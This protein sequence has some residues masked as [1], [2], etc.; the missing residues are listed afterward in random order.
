MESVTGNSLCTTTTAATSTSTPTTVTATTSTISAAPT[1]AVNSSSNANTGNTTSVVMCSSNL[2][3]SVANLPANP[4]I[5]QV[6]DIKQDDSNNMSL[7][8]ATSDGQ[9]SLSGA[10]SASSSPILSPP[11]KIFGRNANGTTLVRLGAHDLTN[12][13]EAN[14]MD[15]RVKRTIVNENFDLKSIANDIA[16]IELST[17]APNTNFIGPI[18][19]PES[20]NFLTQDFVGMNP[21][22][23]GWGSIKYQGATSNVLRDAQ[24][25]IVNRQICEQSY[26]TVFNFINFSDRLICAGNS[27]VDRCQGEFWLALYD[28]TGTDLKYI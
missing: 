1:S 10:P 23:A 19:L 8:S 11:G 12:P 18:C 21:F 28:A 25:P 5:L 17:P 22:I 2:S 26:K 15:F 7:A 6:I 14:A 4:Q 24:V 13:A 20:S 27:N 3:S 9:R 16:L